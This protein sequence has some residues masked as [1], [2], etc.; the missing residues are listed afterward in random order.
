[1]GCK[2]R[3]QILEIQDWSESGGALTA[4]V[5]QVPQGELLRSAINT[6][7]AAMELGRVGA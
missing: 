2:F 3:L 7:A 1:M 5:Q 4:S 6:G